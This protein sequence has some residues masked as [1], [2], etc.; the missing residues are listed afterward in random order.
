MQLLLLLLLWHMTSAAV[1][2]RIYREPSSTTRLLEC[3]SVQLLAVG[4]LVVL[5]IAGAASAAVAEVLQGGVGGR[6][7]VSR[8]TRIFHLLEY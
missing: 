2:K 3:A 7:G 6:G 4:C 1:N 5:V 8:H